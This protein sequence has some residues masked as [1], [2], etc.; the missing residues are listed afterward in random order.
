MRVTVIT[1]SKD[2]GSYIEDCLRSVH[3]QTHR[4]VEHIV[5]DALS[6]DATAAIAAQ[7]PCTFQ[8]KKDTGPAQAINRG[9]EMA[10]GDIICWLNADDMFWSKTTLEEIVG[11][12]TEHPEV[13]VITG[14]GYF[15]SEDGK[16]LQPISGLPERFSLRWMKTGDFI[17]QPATFWRR[18]QFRLDEN[19][20]YCFDWK[21]WIEM[22]QAGLN[23]L[24][25]P[26]YFAR[27]RV[28]SSSLTYQ[29]S[30]SRR[31]EIYGMARQYDG[32]RTQMAW[33]WLV[34]RIY[35]FAEWVGSRRLKRLA[36]AANETMKSLSG[37]RIQSC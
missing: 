15:V 18:N 19:L 16:L 28:H 37:G 32:R 14:N 21:L 4:D 27:Y 10:T 34:W 7:Y 23:L 3:G 17:L 29:D 26:S 13:D 35:Q 6:E 30:A 2:Q 36:C 33:C 24:Y 31:R 12:F 11:T 1:P 9:L 22:L 25:V 5:L 20:H 8:Q